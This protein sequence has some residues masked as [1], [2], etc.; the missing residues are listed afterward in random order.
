VGLY[1]AV[2]TSHTLR[3]LSNAQFYCVP[4]SSPACPAIAVNARLV[5]RYAF[6]LN[7][8]AL[9]EEGATQWRF[10]DVGWASLATLVGA[11]VAAAA[12]EARLRIL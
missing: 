1:Y 11:L 7:L 2:P 6:V 9:P 3:A 12:L 4:I 10:S 8:L 5:P